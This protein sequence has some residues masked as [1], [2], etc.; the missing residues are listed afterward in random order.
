[1][2][3]QYSQQIRYLKRPI[4]QAYNEASIKVVNA[5]ERNRLLHNYLT[6]KIGVTRQH[7]FM[8]PECHIVCHQYHIAI[9]EV[10]LLVPH[11]E[12][13]HRARLPT[14]AAGLDRSGEHAGG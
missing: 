10:V 7:T 14:D 12:R 2:V 5:L 4:G 13:S 8:N 9:I 6:E 11:K 3:I 1:M